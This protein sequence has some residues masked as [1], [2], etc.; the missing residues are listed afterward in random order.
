MRAA[1]FRRYMDWC[2]GLG[3]MAIP[4][5]EDHVAARST[6]NTGRAYELFRSKAALKQ[7]L[8]LTVAELRSLEAS[9]SCGNRLRQRFHW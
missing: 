5:Q 2:S 1:Y 4:V 8:C 7:A 3:V 9:D 6:R